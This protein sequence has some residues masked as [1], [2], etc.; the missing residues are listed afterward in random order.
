MIVSYGMAGQNIRAAARNFAERFPGRERYPSRNVINRCVLRA[1]E[2]GSLLPNFRNCGAP[3]RLNVND[4][5]RI[6]RA[7][8]ENPSNSVRRAARA[9]DLSQSAVYRTLRRNDLRPYHFQRV[10]Q[11]L[12]RD[13]EHRIYFCEDILIIF[14]THLLCF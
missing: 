11:L 1:R 2:T 9:L 4:E 3:G 10:Q 8:E 12:P 5:E 13:H 14:I 6:L 7:F